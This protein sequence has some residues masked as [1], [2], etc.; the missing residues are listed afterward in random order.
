MRRDQRRH[1]ALG[2]PRASGEC[3]Y[4][5]E[6]TIAQLR[7]AGYS[8]R[9]ELASPA[10]PQASRVGS[11]DAGAGAGTHQV[12][13]DGKVY[14]AGPYKGAPLSL[15]T[16]VP[17]VSGP[18]DLGNIV[19]RTAVHVDEET[20]RVSAITDPIPQ[21]IEGI[22]AA[23]PSHPAQPRPAGLHPQPDQLRPVRGRLGP[24]R[25]R[26]R[27]GQRSS[28]FQAANCSTLG[29]RADADA[30][31]EWRRR[32]PRAPGDPRGSQDQTG[33]A[34]TQQRLGDPAEGRAA[35][36]QPHRHDLHPG[37]LRRRHLP[38]GFPDRHGDGDD[39]AARPAAQ[40]RRLPEGL[41][42]RLPDMVLDLRGQVAHRPRR[43]DR[44]RQ[45]PAAHDLLI[46]PRRTGQQGHPDACRRQEGPAP[47]QRRPLRESKK[48]SAKH[49]RPERNRARIEASSCRRPAARGGAANEAERRNTP[50]QSR[51]AAR[52]RGILALL[53]TGPG[54]AAAK[55]FAPYTY[56]GTYPYGSIDGTG[57]G[58]GPGPVR[59]Q[60]EGNR[61]RPVDGQRL[62]RRRRRRRADL[63]QVQLR[64]G[65][66]DRSAP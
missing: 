19:V 21:M 30:E 15:V 33:E 56:N 35:R 52:L 27:G 58:R 18:Y 8:G 54:P 10:C 34:N 26:R 41:I 66:A 43:P 64:R 39:A 40:R 31:A 60:P 13:V 28:F 24:L 57:R 32:P 36:Q 20:A 42:H 59:H 1:A 3:P 38:G 49:D 9:T 62:R 12:Y 25:R 65:G 6:A 2:S 17:A 55:V 37:Q 47:E 63:L 61:R 44:Q 50:V 53:F 45:G 14:L 22:P 48:A 11:V 29:V 7:S 16:V 51:L 4:C 46:G 5:P 23:G